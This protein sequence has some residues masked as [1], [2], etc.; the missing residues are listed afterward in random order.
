MEATTRIDSPREGV[1]VIPPS[2]LLPAE[3]GAV[4]V[5]FVKRAPV[6]VNVDIDRLT[7]ADYKKIQGLTTSA[8]DLP[9][10]EM[11]EKLIDV[12]N[13]V[14]DVDLRSLPARVMNEV[15]NQVVSGFRAEADTKN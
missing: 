14:A 15:I 9:E 3:M 13:L 1:P 8:D 7:W 4:K 12:I 10:T 11:M 6:E 5:N 2:V